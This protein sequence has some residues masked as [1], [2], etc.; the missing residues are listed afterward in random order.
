MLLR[1]FV[2]SIEYKMIYILLELFKYLGF[3]VVC[4][5]LQREEYYSFEKLLLC[6]RITEMETWLVVVI[7]KRH[8]NLI[9]KIYW[10][11]GKYLKH[12]RYHW[13]IYND[14]T[15]YLTCTELNLFSFLFVIKR[16]QFQ[17]VKLS[18]EIIVFNP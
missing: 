3:T 17:R 4:L 7:V 14:T 5:F 12:F 9:G 13:T 8:L 15:S 6:R 2:H 18:F 16:F 1:K 10:F 11:N